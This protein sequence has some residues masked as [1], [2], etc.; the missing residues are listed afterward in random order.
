MNRL[1]S[2]I[3]TECPD[4]ILCAIQLGDQ[5]NLRNWKNDN[6]YSFF[7]QELITPAVQQEWFEAYLLRNEDYM[8]VIKSGTI[9]I[10]CIGFRLCKMNWDVYNT[11]LGDAVFRSRGYMRQAMRMICS[12][13]LTLKPLPITTKVIST[14]SAL[15]WYYRNSFRERTVNADYVDIELNTT[16]FTPCILKE[17]AEPKLWDGNIT[18]ANISRD[19]Q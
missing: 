3:S 17:V 12:Y 1:F 14:N 5:E 18:K 7:Y 6:R 15:R 11:I 4:V 19:S 8:F 13:A 16:S 9:K 2:L 10:G